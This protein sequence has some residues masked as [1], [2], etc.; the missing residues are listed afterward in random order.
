MYSY[1]RVECPECG[2]QFDVQLYGDHR[3]VVCPECGH[4]FYSGDHTVPTW[5]LPRPDPSPSL[6]KI[7]LFEGYLEASF[8]GER[9]EG[10]FKEEI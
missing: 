6:V 3:D 5:M 4:D 9:G 7:A 8:G 2:H 10:G 1:A